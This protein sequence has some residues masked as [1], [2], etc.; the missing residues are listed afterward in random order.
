MICLI[1]VLFSSLFA[2]W[3]TE[4]SENLK[5]AGG[6]IN[7]EIC[8]DDAGGCYILWETG[9]LPN[10]RLLRIQHLDRF[11]FKLFPEQGLPVRLGEFDQANQFLFADGLGGA[12]AVFNELIPVADTFKVAVFAQRFDREGVRVWGD[13]AVVVSPSEHRQIPL[14]AC[15]DGTGGAFVFLTEDRDQDGDEELYG[16][17]IDV[18]GSRV[19]GDE[20]VLIVDTP[21]DIDADAVSSDNGSVIVSFND[22]LE[23]VVQKFTGELMPLWEDAVNAGLPFRSSFRRMVSD[24]FGGVVLT[25]KER[26]FFDQ[27]SFFRLWAQRIDSSGQIVW[28]DGVVL[29]DS[30]KN[31]AVAPKVAV[32]DT[33]FYFAWN[34]NPENKGQTFVQAV[35]GQGMKLFG[36]ET[37]PVSAANSAKAISDAVIAS[38]NEFIVVWHD[39]RNIQSFDL[40][41]QLI[42]QTADRL[43]RDSDVAIS[44][45]NA[46]QTDPR[47]TDDGQGG[48]IVVWYEIGAGTGNGVFV[49]QISRNGKLGDVIVSIE[50]PRL[51]SNP[52]SFYLFQ[53]Y[54]N[55]FNPSM[56]IKYRIPE[57]SHVTLKIF[58]ITGKEVITLVDENQDAGVHQITWNGKD[59]KGGD[60]ASGLYFCP[61]RAGNFVQTKKALLIK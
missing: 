54:P 29:A 61:L 50:E 4:P 24:E 28:D 10:R 35:N 1:H 42:D 44:T 59:E 32:A 12:I 51:E 15:E 14:A 8:T 23:V 6:A 40:Y 30:I 27:E 38:G 20:G 52:S 60:V 16:N 57:F 36:E 19:L 7:P 47:A 39:N 3:S 58:D 48:I 26:S 22:S 43:W 33:L 31:P 18:E 41:G 5:I 21:I 55:P 49:Q 9:A 17:R 34:E 45:R 37:F 2:Q 56:T 46:L 25:C 13:S 53:S 11:G